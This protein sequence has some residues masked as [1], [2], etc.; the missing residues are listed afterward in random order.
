MIEDSLK[1]IADA[2][3]IIA[4]GGTL[5]APAK[6]PKKVKDVPAP[7]ADVPAPPVADVPAPPVAEVPAA[8]MTVE[9]LN[10]V[11]VEHHTRLGGTPE[12]YAQIQAVMLEMGLKGS[13]DAIN[14]PEGCQKLI[15]KVGAL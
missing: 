1:R 2:L 15:K 6:K 14:N 12:A 3:E 13:Q 10:E 7:P 9:E 5:E 11:L 4:M 8:P